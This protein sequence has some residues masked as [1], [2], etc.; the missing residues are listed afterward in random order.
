MSEFAF[1]PASDFEEEAETV[2]VEAVAE[3]VAEPEVKKPEPNATVT[4]DSVFAAIAAKR[5]EHD[6]AST[7]LWLNTSFPI[8]TDDADEIVAQLNAYGIEVI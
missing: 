6:N 2:A 1:A 3:P 4:L 7:A 8:T 5:W